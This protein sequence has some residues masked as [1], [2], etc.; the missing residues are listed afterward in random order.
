MT[1]LVEGANGAHETRHQIRSTLYQK[2]SIRRVR[3]EK[4]REH[5]VFQAII[6]AD[7]RE[8]EGR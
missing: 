7:R 4:E 2:R 5:D 8:Q 1:V 3:R 6:L